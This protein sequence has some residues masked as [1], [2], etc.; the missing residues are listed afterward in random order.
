MQ[1][2]SLLHPL[3]SEYA[4]NRLTEEAINDLS[5]DF[6][7]DNLTESRNERGHLRSLMTRVTDDPAVIRYRQATFADICSIEGLCEVLR[8][9]LPF[10]TDIREL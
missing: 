7:L 2:F 8:R 6:L 10:L 9:M 3:S 5:I 4:E 1:E